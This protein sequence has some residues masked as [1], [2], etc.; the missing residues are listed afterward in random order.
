MTTRR[1]TLAICALLP[2]L[3]GCGGTNPPTGG[4][5]GGAYRPGSVDQG[6]YM[7]RDWPTQPGQNLGQPGDWW[8]TSTALA[9]VAAALCLLLALAAA[10][11]DG[12]PGAW[13]EHHTR[14]LAPTPPHHPGDRPG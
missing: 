12:R 3:T 1:A 2:V 14:W 5:G 4:P 9:L 10:A 7:V 8:S 6:L 13:L 11:A